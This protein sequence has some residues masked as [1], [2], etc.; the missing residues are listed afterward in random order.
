MRVKN[1][2]SVPSV[3]NSTGVVEVCDGADSLTIICIYHFKNGKYHNEHIPAIEYIDFVCEGELIPISKE[4]WTNGTLICSE[5]KGDK[6]LLEC[7]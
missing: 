1:L 4:W 2:E 6:K 7:F 5:P 3:E